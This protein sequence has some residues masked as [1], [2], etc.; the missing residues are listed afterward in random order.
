MNTQPESEFR[1][2]VESGP[3]PYRAPA[4]PAGAA[5][6][7]SDPRSKQVVLACLLS[8]CPGLGQIYV[9]YYQR[10]FVHAAT[11]A[12]IIALL[13]EGDPPDVFYPLLGVFLPFFWMYNIIDAGRRAA[14]YN[15]ALLGM[16]DTFEMPR[17]ISIPGGGSIA[18]GLVLVTL[19]TLLL[20][21]TRYD[22]SLQF[23]E[24]WWPVAPILLGLYLIGKAVIER[25]PTS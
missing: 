11:V 16:S 8:L 2:P 12:G 9:G 6:L 5:A 10:G 23:L 7:A 13:A 22:V 24:D 18:G 17:D 20:L 14:F 15:Q 21:H 25:R 1:P 3:A 19:G 4:P